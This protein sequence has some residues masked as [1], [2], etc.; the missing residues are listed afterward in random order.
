MSGGGLIEASG[1]LGTQLTSNGSGGGGRVALHVGQLVGF[2]PMNQVR[3]WGGTKYGPVYAAPG[4]VLVRAG[5]EIYGRLIVDNGQADGLDRVGP[6][7]ELPSLG[8][9]DVGAWLAEGS[10][11]WLQGA[12]AFRSDWLGVWAV[13]LSAGGED[14]GSFEVMSVDPAGRL[15]LRGAGSVASP[16]RYRG[17]YR[18]DGVE[19]RHGAK[20]ASG[21]VMS[22][23]AVVFEGQVGLSASVVDATDVTVRT[24]AVLSSANG[25]RVRLRASGR[26]TIEAGSRV[27]VS[28]QGYLGGASGIVGGSPAGVRGSSS[29]SGGSHG[30]VGLSR[31]GVPGEVYDSVYVP[32][33]AG[34]G[35]SWTNSAKPGS[36]G[37]VVE[38]EAGELVLE[39]ELRARG[40]EINFAGGG[41][42]SVWVKAGVLSGGG[43]IDA[44]ATP[45]VVNAGDGTAGGGGRVGLHVGQMVGFDAVSQVRAWGGNYYPAVPASPGTVLVRE[46]SQLYGRLLV[47]NGVTST[48]ADRVGPVTEL[49]LLGSGAISGWALEGSDSW[50]QGAT[51]F[52]SD[53]LGVSV[54]LLG[55]NGEDLGSFEVM[56][57]DPAGRLRLRGAASVASPTRYRGE[58]RF[59]GVELRHG[60]KLVSGDVLSMGSVVFEGQV[61]LSAAVVDATDVTLRTGAVLSSANGDRVRLKASGRLTV[62]AS[63][64]VDVTG[65]GYLGGSSGGMG[66]SPA[67]VR[68]S[69][70]VS[71]GSHGGVGL[72]E[73]GVAGEVYDSVY[74]PHLAGGG[75]SWTSALKPGSGGGVIE[76]EAGELVLEGELRARSQETNSSGGAGGSIWVKAGVLSGAGLIDASCTPVVANTAGTPGGGGRVGLHVGQLVGFDTLSQVRVWGGDDYPAVP[77]APGTVLVREGGQFYGRLIVDNGR[78]ASN[79]PRSAPLS[80]LPSIGSGSIGFTEPDATD[81][82]DLWIEPSDPAQTFSNGVEGMWVRFAAA[83]FR[84][85]ALSADRR[86]LLLDGAASSVSVG[87]AFVGLYRFDSVAVRN[88]AKLQLFDQLDSPSIMVDPDSQLILP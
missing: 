82:S 85:L 6:V 57:V 62:E 3:V 80:P 38:I 59:D 87:E 25:D 77:A 84:V 8:S 67:G 27:D 41:G 70:S 72:S 7:T 83:D 23:G 11:A 54:V 32:H 30:G 48:G 9:G 81:S 49:P 45:V 19:L 79:L 34:G 42:G 46:G 56:S 78:T 75:G 4:T 24:G 35:G 33:L 14:L 52:P 64:R 26:V 76:I 15:R 2:D 47:D 40:Q 51:A 17:E 71:G 43:V 20:L 18:F 39:G 36:G 63:S 60:A 65:Q 29:S 44:S 37:G 31:G 28:G 1:G 21:D 50:L 74:V 13:L 61:G 86:R 55:T 22:M 5:T 68:G 58:Y 10:D 66:G 88:G 73:G 16:A 53:W 12:A 69:T